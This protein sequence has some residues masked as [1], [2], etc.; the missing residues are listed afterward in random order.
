MVLDAARRFLKVVD[1]SGADLDA[2]LI[3]NIKLNRRQPV[4]GCCV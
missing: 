2:T 1:V 3:Y 4:E